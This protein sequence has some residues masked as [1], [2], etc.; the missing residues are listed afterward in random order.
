MMYYGFWIMNCRE[1]NIKRSEL[2][3]GNRDWGLGISYLN[4]LRFYTPH[5]IF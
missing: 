1:N 4:F 5:L 3:L 2:G